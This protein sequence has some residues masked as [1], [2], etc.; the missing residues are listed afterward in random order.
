M[1]RGW[2]ILIALLLV[3]AGLLWLNKVIVDNETEGAE[4]T[5]AGGRILR[6]AGGDVQVVERGPRSGDTIVLLPCFSCAINWWEGMFP[7]LDRTERVVAMDLRGFGGSEKPVSGY[8]IDDQAGLVAEALARLGVRS[9][10][11]VGHSLGGTVA[12]ALAERSPGLVARLVLIDQAPDNSYEAQGLSFTATLTF[13]PVL[14]EAVWQIAPDFAVRDG[15]GVAFAPGFDVP[16]R[17]VTDFRRM[18][19]TSYDKSTSAED[20]YLSD[21]PLDRRIERTGKPLLAIFGA[22][23][24]VYDARKALAA[25]SAVPGAMTKLV[26]GAGHSPNVEAPRTIAALVLAFAKSRGKHVPSARGGAVSSHGTKRR[27]TS[28]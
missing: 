24:Q 18:T 10:T 3:A 6:L 4:I 19:Y 17:F 1:G 12:T 21:I 5:E 14:G 20:D 22:E 9:A 7:L 13:L 25:Y 8:S 16:D 27:K 11:I 28:R 2:K 26:P 23:D 15:L